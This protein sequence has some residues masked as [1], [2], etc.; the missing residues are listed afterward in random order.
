MTTSPAPARASV[1][2]MR[3][4]IAATTGRRSANEYP[5][6]PRATLTR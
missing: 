5:K 1:L 2:G 4:P 3:S 6:S